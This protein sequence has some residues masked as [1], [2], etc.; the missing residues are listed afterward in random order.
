[1]TLLDNHPRLKNNPKV[2]PALNNRK[3]QNGSNKKVTEHEVILVPMGGAVIGIS[4]IGFARLF[5]EKKGDKK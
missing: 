2:N 4:P 5:G 1:M 3:K